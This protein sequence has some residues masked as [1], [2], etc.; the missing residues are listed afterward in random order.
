MSDDF[1]IEDVLRAS[2]AERARQAPPADPLAERIIAEADHPRRVHDPRGPRRWQGWMLPAVAAASVVAVVATIVGLVQLKHSDKHAADSNPQDTGRRSSSSVTSTESG[3]LY[4]DQ[5]TDSTALPSPSVGKNGGDVPD[6]F[7][8]MD[9]TFITE[10][11]GWALGRGICLSGEPGTCP[12]ILRT[13]DGGAKWIS[14][15]IPPVDIEPACSSSPCVSNLRFA[16][17]RVGY[18]YGPGALYMTVDG[19]QTWGDPQGDAAS[20]EV[21]NDT[22][23]RVTGDKLQV[24]KVGTTSWK[25]AAL[26]AKAIVTSP[27]VRALRHA[28]V[29]AASGTSIY[30]SKD[31]GAHWTQ[32]NGPCSRPGSLNSMSA[33][34]DGTLAV[35]CLPA[36]KSDPTLWVS[37]DDGANFS[38][39]PGA[40]VQ[41]IGRPFGAANASTLFRSSPGQLERSTDGG[42]HWTR[43]ASDKTKSDGA[44]GFLGF[45][46]E[47]TGRWVTGDGSTIYTTT[48]G[49]Q[50]WTPY[51]FK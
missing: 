11:N 9:L 13:D 44:P 5:P 25:P 17:D 37:N 18:A 19:G 6:R 41:N 22:A 42:Q 24:S 30:A 15:P 16:N 38:P 1:D 48:D 14:T 4:R 23:L 32:E 35:M 51:T 26:P 2:L 36:T 12:A 27:V 47:T 45:E 8:V 20:L 34:A 21:A 7:K 33:G 49:G 46:S 50:H 39:V 29:P 10:Q 31:D 43:V 28:Y 3:Q 40:S